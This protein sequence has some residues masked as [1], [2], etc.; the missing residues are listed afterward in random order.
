MDDL[1]GRNHFVRASVGALDDCGDNFIP[2]GRVQLVSAP[3]DFHQPG[4]INR[5][6]DGRSMFDRENRISCA[7]N[8]QKGHFHLGQPILPRVAD[9][10]QN[11]M[12]GGAEVAA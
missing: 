11:A 10:K 7:V 8:D 9:L 3:F 6:C 5:R 12:I 2:V 4:S 1:V